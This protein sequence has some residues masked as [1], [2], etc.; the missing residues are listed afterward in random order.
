MAEALP[1][2]VARRKPD[3]SRLEEMLGRQRRQ[4]L[5][6]A[7][8]STLDALYRRVSADLAVAQGA[9]AGTDVVRFLNQL[10]ATAYASIYR[11]RGAPLESLRTFYL[12]TFPRLVQ[13]T[14]GPIQ[15][16]AGLL[17]FGVVLGALAVVLHPDGGR[18]LVGAELRSIIDRGELWTDSALAARTPTEMA[19][20]IFLNNVKVMISAF[21]FGVTGGVLTVLV[22]LG[23]GLHIGAVA[24][25]CFQ[26]GVGWNILEFM[27]AHGPV[28]LSLICIAGGA[29]L[30]LG[31]ALLEPGE[32]SRAAAMREHAQ[33]AVQL[34]LGAAP[35]MVAIGVVEGFVSPGAFFPWPLKA[36]VGAAS[37]FALWRWLLRAPA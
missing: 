10:C 25:A 33:V 12:R 34:V 5:T 32:R 26:G 37:G 2:F 13:Q 23:N 20:Q 16:A 19:V 22:L 31:R 21:A 24:A 9:Y 8:L 30:H 36:L 6:L 3:W 29:G 7:D 15:L 28:E 4:Q 14:L 27:T 1:A 11:P 18:V 35:F 17:V